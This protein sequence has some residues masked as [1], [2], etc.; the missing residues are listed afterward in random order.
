MEHSP[1]L[2][3]NRFQVGQEFPRTV[4]NPKAYYR[5]YKGPPHVPILSPMNPIHAS[6]SQ[7]LE[8]QLNI[9]PHLRLVLPSGLFP[10]DFATKTLNALLFS[11][12]R[13]TYN[14][15]LIILVLLTCRIVDDEYKSLSFT[16]YRLFHFAVNSS[17]FRP[18]I[19][20]KDTC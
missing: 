1:S 20:V 8:I 3:A 19:T 11:P 13:A 6:P 18:N 12:V 5:I 15:H 10:S 2:E 9:I 17:F 4:W 14:A 16:L 7:F